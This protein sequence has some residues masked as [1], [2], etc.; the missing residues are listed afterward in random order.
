LT[1]PTDPN[2]PSTIITWFSALG[3][4]VQGI[5]WSGES[6]G[7]C[8]V[9]VN[10]LVTITTSLSL[11]SNVLIADTPQLLISFLYLFYNNI[12]A[13]M[14]L[15]RVE[16][17]DQLIPYGL[18]QARQISACGRSREALVLDLAVGGIMVVALLA[19]GFRRFEKG[20]PVASSCNLAISTA[21]HPPVEGR[22]TGLLPMQYGA[23]LCHQGRRS[24]RGRDGGGTGI[25]GQYRPAHSK[26]ALSLGNLYIVHEEK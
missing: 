26:I 5:K 10:A 11:V 13:C 1:F 7:F 6:S 14:L 20:I 19:S 9:S 17:Y 3:L 25:L 4:L 16:I 12:F 15:A 24:F 22:D 23:P 21:C 8:T 18:P 2:L